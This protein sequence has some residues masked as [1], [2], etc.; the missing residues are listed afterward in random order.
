MDIFQQF[1]TDEAAEEVG[2]WITIGKDAK[3]KVARSGNTKYVETLARLSTEHAETLERKDE[4]AAKLNSTL[5]AQVVAESLLKDWS[6][7]KYK[8]QPISYSLEN[9]VTLLK[10]KDFRIKV[11]ELA[12]EREHFLLKEEAEAGKDSPASSTGS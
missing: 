9:A 3:L 11:L 8:G 12:S 1:A 6:G 2:T 4:E 7:L 10:H 5:M